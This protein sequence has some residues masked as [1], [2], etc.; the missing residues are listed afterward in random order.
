VLSDEFSDIWKWLSFQCY[1]KTKTALV[2]VK[3]WHYVR[4]N[5]NLVSVHVEN[6]V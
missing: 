2:S 1:L 6:Y 3:K 5:V 4:S